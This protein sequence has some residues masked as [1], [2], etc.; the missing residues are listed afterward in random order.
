[1]ARDCNKLVGLSPLGDVELTSWD[2]SDLETASRLT[3]QAYEQTIDQQISFHYQS[4]QGCRN[5]LGGIVEKPGCGRFMK[6]ASFC[7]WHRSTGEMVGFILASVVS[8]L[9]GHI[10]Q[11]LVSQRFQG[12]GIGSRLLNQGIAALQSKSCR[13]VSLSVTAE[14]K[15]AYEL[16]R[17]F[18]FDI[19][20]RFRTSVW[21][22]QTDG[23]RT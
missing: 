7:A 18:Q 20:I 15:A 9:N 23:H 1:M 22:R 3:V 4:L 21:K 14:N 2:M 16:Y 8:P 17:R 13:T 5:F 12:K 10:P 6:D 19:L 11:I